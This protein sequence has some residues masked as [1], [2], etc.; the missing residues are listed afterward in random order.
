MS[1]RKL[2]TAV[3][4]AAV[5]VAGIL[6]AHGSL[7]AAAHRRNS[8]SL[9][10]TL[11][12]TFGSDTSS[13][14]NFAQSLIRTYATSE[15]VVSGNYTITKVELH[16]LRV[17]SGTAPDLVA[18]IRADAGTQPDTP[19]LATSTNT[20]VSADVG[21]SMQWVTFIF[22]GLA[23]TNGTTYYIGVKASSVD[24]SNYYTARS[25]AFGTGEIRSSQ[26]GTTTWG[27]EGT[28]PWWIR[29]YSSP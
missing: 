13:T 16:M 18:E 14:P 28:R 22:A 9:T 27:T 23:V 29:T 11:Q 21:T 2:F 4:V 20:I 19:P 5:T 1:R 8:A 10:Y 15:V 12:Q 24:A 17:G 6:Q 25:G 7:L 3:L 26:L